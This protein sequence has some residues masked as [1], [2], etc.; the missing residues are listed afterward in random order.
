[1][2]NQINCVFEDVPTDLD[3]F[4]IASQIV[5]AEAKKYFIEFWRMNKGERN[6]ILWW[7][8]RDG[9][10]VVSDAV[11]DYYGNKKL[12]YDYIKRAQTDVCVMVGDAESGK[13][14]LVIVND[15]RQKVSGAVVVKNAETGKIVFSG[16]FNASK[17]S[18]STIASIPK[19]LS[20]SMWLIEWKMN[21][22][23]YSNHYLAYE[24][25]VRLDRYLNWQQKIN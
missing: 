3:S 19:P 18:K 24:P 1:M 14:P 20:N 15:S 23:K 5:Q 11:V 21:G 8:L 10:P 2:I 9:W 6:G 22:N 16:K 7:N 17:N 12:A 13:H 4:I 25:P